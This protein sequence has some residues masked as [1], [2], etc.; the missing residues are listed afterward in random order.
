M[1]TCPS[2]QNFPEYC[3]REPIDLTPALDCYQLSC[4]W[5]IEYTSQYI[6]WVWRNLN[7][8]VLLLIPSVVEK[9]QCL[10]ELCKRQREQLV[11]IKYKLQFKEKD[12]K[13]LKNDRYV[14]N[15]LPVAESVKKRNKVFR[16]I[17]F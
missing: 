16:A 5:G 2:L 3:L 8:L 14:D 15:L 17:K 6:T 10:V 7:I 11:I 1:G 12:E 13:R 4:S 9:P